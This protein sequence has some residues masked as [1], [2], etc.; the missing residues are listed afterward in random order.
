MTRATL[1]KPKRA[2]KA[3][4]P[5]RE[6]RTFRSAVNFLDSLTN[7]ERATRAQYTPS[8]FG[9]AR[10]NRLLT[11]LG[12]PH[13]SFKSVHIAG[14]KGKGST[15]VMLAEMLRACGMKV[16]LYTSPHLLNIRERIVVDGQQIS[17]S[18]F[19]KAV[20]AVAAIATK[21]RVPRPTYFEVLTVA[22]FR[23]F[24]AEKVDVAVVETGLGGRLDA[25]N[26][27]TPEVVGI[28]SISY[29]HV[30]QL[31]PDLASIA[32]EKAGVIKKGIPVVSAPQP[33]TAREALR[34]AAEA[35]GAPL[36]FADEDVDFTYRFE[37]SRQVGRH[38]R[39][40]LTTPTS[41]FEHLH[42]P[43]LGAHQA[44]N[45]GLALSML[46][47]L[48]SR[49]FPVEDR[50]ATSGLNN[51]KLPGRMQ[52]ICEEP[53]ILVDAAH[54]AASIDALMRAIGQNINYDSMIVIFGCH[55]DKDIPGMIRRIQL[56][57]DKMIFTGT[58][59]PRSADPAELA[60]LYME[61]SGKM[62]Q[63][64]STLDEAMRIAGGAVTREDLICITGS[65]YLVGEAIR[66]YGSKPPQ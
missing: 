46:D 42:V 38:A 11:A 52:M 45:C 13:R 59:S 29:D 65:F 66:K 28:T 16:G 63:V 8:N 2:P 24:A 6:V 60:T 41:K 12:K 58:S 4:T 17:E 40:G 10:T 49:G 37:F 34:E 23:Y 56:G 9:L 25:T 27:I 33:A 36:R 48:K 15:A 1:E 35:N 32:Q 7:Y 21:A 57:A 20:A 61:R 54:N 51:V 55:K 44:M 31:G 18:A 62:A 3:K 43:L 30:A 50:Q 14:T 64:A 39:I 22:A 19:T 26:V 53:R 5:R 47:V